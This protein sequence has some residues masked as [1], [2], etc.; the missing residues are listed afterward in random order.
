MLERSDRRLPWLASV[1]SLVGLVGLLALVIVVG[2]SGCGPSQ[3]AIVDAV[4]DAP[5]LQLAAGST[6]SVVSSHDLGVTLPPAAQAVVDE[7]TAATDGPDDPARWILDQLVAQLPASV[8]G[9]ASDLEPIVAAYLLTEIDQVAP[10][11]A[12]GVQQIAQGLTRIAHQFGTR[13]TLQLDS[14]THAIRRITGLH[15]DVGSRDVDLPF[16]DHGL[17]DAI[18]DV[19]VSIATTGASAGLVTFG[20]HAFAL[21]YGT[22]LRLGLDGAAVPAADPAATDL[23]SALRDLVDCAHLGELVSD[24]VGVG[25][26]EIYEVACDAGM[27]AA[28]AAVDDKLAALDAVAFDMQVDGTAF[29]TDHDGDGLVDWLH[30]GVWTGNVSYG[31][32]TS[33]IAAATFTSIDP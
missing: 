23:A 2:A 15:F 7:L 5:P 31:G 4:P 16:A 1:L 25:S 14:A 32:A 11:F 19:D 18:A 8:Q 9:V 26:P 24:E 13:E 12:V 33:P 21:P 3:A 17:A 20:P 27:T 6:L 10:R 30:A 22:L 28:A 29:G